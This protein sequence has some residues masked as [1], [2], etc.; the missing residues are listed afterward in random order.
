MGKNF[1]HLWF[2]QILSQV[3]VNMMNFLL[4]ARLFHV[5]GS[6]IATSLLWVAY[7]LPAIFFGPIGAGLADFVS[8]RKTLLIT[9]LLQ[10][11]AVLLYILSYNYSIF[12]TFVVVIIYS[13]LNQFYVPAESASLPSAVSKNKLPKANSM[14]FITQQ[15]ALIV[16][17]G[18][19]G[20]I[21]KFIGFE[22][23][24]IICAVN[25]FLAFISVSFLPNFAPRKIIPEDREEIMKAFFN[26]IIEGYLFIK[27]RKTIIYSLGLLFLIQ[28]GL[29]MIFVNL[30]VIALEILK[31]ATSYV[32]VLVV[33]PAGIGATIGSIYI[34]KLI[35]KGWRK[36]K[37][38]NMGLIALGVGV[39]AI[40][41][42]IPFIPAPLRFISG[43]ILIVLIGFGF[44]AVN[45]PTLT[46]LQEIVPVW[47]RGRVFGNLY[48]LIT[49]TTIFP[50]IFSGIISE[51]FGV[52]TLLTMLS[53]GVILVLSY[54]VRSGQRL[55]D[56][57]F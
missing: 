34:N 44:I 20:I 14:F 7:A 1:Y 52:K 29:A 12:S 51:F 25:L 6:A 31:V 53:I 35:K 37:I 4:L 39:F 3:T 43:P 42:A 24:L 19:A 40:A 48:F 5:T 45:I 28:V 36:K 17:F 13:L 27:N 33:V 38:I 15:I 23:A 32:G 21:E 30:P 2:S 16:G 46:F 54:S 8:R 9:N 56:E 41:W 10:S 26:H 50:I 57:N 55:I 18:F 49:I 47:L 22:G 11:L